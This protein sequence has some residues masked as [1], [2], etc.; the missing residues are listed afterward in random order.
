MAKAVEIVPTQPNFIQN[1][2]F[3]HKE[4]LERFFA[5]K[6]GVT[7]RPSTEVSPEFRYGKELFAYGARAARQ[8]FT[9]TPWE[10]EEPVSFERV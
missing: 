2:L 4:C 10:I 7:L 3:L 1:T 8:G 5:P 6:P 9:E